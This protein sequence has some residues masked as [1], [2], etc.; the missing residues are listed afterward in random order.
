[1]FCQKYNHNITN[2][3]AKQLTVGR[4]WHG[5]LGLHSHL[6]FHEK[7]QETEHENNKNNQEKK[8]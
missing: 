5:R 8:Y 2:P 1:M 4:L 6:L 3:E 7:I